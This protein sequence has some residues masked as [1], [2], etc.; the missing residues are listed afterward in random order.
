MPAPQHRLDILEVHPPLVPVGLSPVLAGTDEAQVVVRPDSDQPGCWVGLDGQLARRVEAVR[1]RQRYAVSAPR[2]TIFGV[3]VR[4]AWSR[5]TSGREECPT[6]S[7][8]D[9]AIAM[10]EKSRSQHGAKDDLSR[11][12]WGVVVGR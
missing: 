11:D 4:L 1:L 10:S 3:G 7:A 9:F 6:G 8:A 5:K 12:W 2:W